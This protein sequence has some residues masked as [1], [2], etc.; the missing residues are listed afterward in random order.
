MWL[1]ALLKLSTL[2]GMLEVVLE[3]L[4]KGGAILLR[5]YLG[6]GIGT[7]QLAHMILCFEIAKTK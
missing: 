5:Q 3:M 1:A 2:L 4:G 7:R 6:F